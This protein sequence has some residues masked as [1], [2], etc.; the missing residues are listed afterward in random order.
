MT[1]PWSSSS[2]DAELTMDVEKE[3]R[4]PV[5]FELVEVMSFSHMVRLFRNQSLLRLSGMQRKDCRLPTFRCKFQLGVNNI[6]VVEFFSTILISATTTKHLGTM[7][8]ERKPLFTTRR[9]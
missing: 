7:P 4:E 2:K 6:K 9:Q 8:Q 3:H 1:K 5:Q